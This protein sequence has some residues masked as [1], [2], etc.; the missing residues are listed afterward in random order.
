MPRG[1]EVYKERI[2]AYSLG[3]FC[4]WFGLNVQDLNGLAPL[5]WVD[6]EADGRLRSMSI[7]SFEQQS[8]HYPIPDP[9]KKAEKLIRRLSEEDF[10]RFPVEYVSDTENRIPSLS[11]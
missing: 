10:G 7:Y 4:T 1:I 5:L 11:E 3:N 6:V 9:D 8:R 2:I